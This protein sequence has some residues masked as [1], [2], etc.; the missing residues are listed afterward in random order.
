AMAAGAAATAAGGPAAGMVAAKMVDAAAGDKSA[1]KA[2]EEAKQAAK[3]D[4]KLAKALGSAEKAVAQTTAAYHVADTALSAAEGD[5]GAAREMDKLGSAAQNGDKAAM[6]ALDLVQK[7]DLGAKMW[8]RATGRGPDVSSALP[9]P[10][11]AVSGDYEIAIR[12]QAKAALRN[13]HRQRGG[14]YMGEAGF[15][16]SSS[17]TL[18]YRRD[19]RHEKVYFFPS[20]A[21]AFQWFQSAKAERPDYLTCVD[22]G[23][24]ESAGPDGRL[25]FLREQF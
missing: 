23:Q 25:V 24:L 2:L 22:R 13:A 20:D 3:S 16:G 7:S 4:P 9:I 21:D 14:K 18:G 1:A 15:G 6:M 12:E 10:A 11:A 19:G 8:T 17:Q 5:G